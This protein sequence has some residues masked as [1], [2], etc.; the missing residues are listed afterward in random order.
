MCPIVPEGFLICS[1]R[2]N[3]CLNLFKDVVESNEKLIWT[4]FVIRLPVS[5][6][7]DWLQLYLH[8]PCMGRA[9]PAIGHSQPQG[10]GTSLPVELPESLTQGLQTVTNQADLLMSGL[11]ESQRSFQQSRVKVCFIRYPDH[12]IPQERGMSEKTQDT[13]FRLNFR[14]R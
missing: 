1:R 8:F 3:R 5:K 14:Y 10:P 13:L 6:C 12:G 2:D 7:A 4:P 11:E 9:P